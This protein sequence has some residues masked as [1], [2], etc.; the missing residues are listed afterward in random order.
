MECFDVVIVG[1][2]PGGLAAAWNARL[3]GLSV[4]VIN[5]SHILGYGLHGAYKSKGMWELAKDVLV[6]QKIGRGYHPCSGPIDFAEVGRQIQDG[7]EEL[8]SMYVDQLSR[9]GI[10]ML[11][12]FAHFVDPHA[13]EVEGQ[14]IQGKSLIIATGTRPKIP[15]GVEVD[16]KSILTSD[17][18]VDLPKLFE[19]VTIL[20]AGVIGCEFAS[21]LAAFG[22]KVTLID[23]Q[24][25]VLASE[26]EDVS[27]F[28]SA[29]FG[30]RHID[31]LQGRR[32]SHIKRVGDRV[33]VVLDDG[34]TVESEAALLAMG[35]TAGTESLGL[36]K[37]GIVTDAQGYVV[38]NDE[39]QT[40]VPHI[41]AVGDVA[42]KMHEEAAC[43]VHV[44]E[45]EG[46]HAAA[47]ILGA[48]GG[49]Q[50]GH[51]PFIIFT[52]PMIAGVG[53]NETQ[54]RKRHGAVRVVRFENARNHRLHAMRSFEGFV[55]LI[56]GPEG[57][58]RILG[59]RAVGPQADTLIG[60][61]SVMIQH[62]I[63]YTALPDS[64]HAHPSLSESLQN[65]ARVLAGQLP[66]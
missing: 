65:A 57:D 3:R 20:G 39:M 60:E 15:A 36:E 10:K 44:A 9:V 43:L 33:R 34:A 56:V 66:A 46:R 28:L 48:K 55:K 62:G 45:A 21:I 32:M 26:D 14:Q 12:G 16:G 61:V 5:G 18:V 4:A 2:G 23:S 42:R 38:I 64:F 11:P 40:S 1:G 47:S 52:H 58:D 29:V 17:H 25:R 50:Y 54:A 59:V 7:T 19:S 37:V 41:Y 35:R 24:L 22:A 6:A 8:A 63:P 53:E 31:L 30:R 49:I 13:V 27:R 51:V